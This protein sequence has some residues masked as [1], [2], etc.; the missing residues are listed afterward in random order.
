[1]LIQIKHGN[2]IYEPPIKNGATLQR[3]KNAASVFNFTIVGQ[4]VA[5]KGA[6]GTLVIGEGDLVMVTSHELRPLGTGHKI[7][8]GYVFSLRPDKN[9]EIEVTAYDQV[10][11]LKNTDTFSYENKTAT[12]VLKMICDNCRIKYGSD[13]MNTGYIIPSR[14]EDNKEYLD[15]LQTAI[16]LTRDN[17]GKEFVLWDNYGEIALHDSDF[18]KTNITIDKDTAQDFSFETSIDSETYNQIKLYR[19]LDDKTKESFTASNGDTIGQWGLLQHSESLNKD[20]NGDTKAQTLLK[21]FN[22]KT[23]TLSVSGAF[24]DIRIRGGSV[25]YVQLD[26]AALGISLFGYTISA[27]CRVES[28]THTFNADNHVMD[29]ELKGDD[30]LG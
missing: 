22:R 14:I 12:D 24:G 15:M 16:D 19:E 4:E 11:Y 27:W 29:L 26:T 30:A 20:E 9:G 25:V 23:R 5:L 18:F 6:D 1:M 13:I 7:F 3:T 28:V 8:F 17:T 21:Q 2:A 10:R